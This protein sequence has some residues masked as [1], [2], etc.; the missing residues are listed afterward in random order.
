MQAVAD[1]AGLFAHRHTA[2]RTRPPELYLRVSE[3]PHFREILR[4]APPGPSTP[5]ST[6][7]R[8]SPFCW[9][10]SSP[11]PLLGAAAVV[12]LPADRITELIIRTIR[13]AP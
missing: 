9:A 11:A 3:R 2:P 12:P 8:P 4:A 7:T 1:H 13:P 10:P 6:P 5:R